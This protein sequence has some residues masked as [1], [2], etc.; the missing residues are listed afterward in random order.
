M[1][2]NEF[3]TKTSKRLGLA[4]VDS[5]AALLP[6]SIRSLEKHFKFQYTYVAIELTEIFSEALRSEEQTLDL[7]II[8][9]ILKEKLP[10]NSHTYGNI[11]KLELLTVND[12]KIDEAEKLTL[13]TAWKYV[14]VGNNKIQVNF[15]IDDITK[16]KIRMS[17][18]TDTAR[19]A[20]NETDHILFTKYPKIIVNRLLYD[21]Y[22]QERKEDL[23][24]FYLNE[25]RRL[26]LDYKPENSQLIFVKNI[27]LRNRSNTTYIKPDEQLQKYLT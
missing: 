6:F 13:N 25:L 14:Y 24:R 22:I 27:G 2:Q 11:N 15:T 12:T 1:K 23:S 26:S 3:L 9:R 21:Y 18:L 8:L 7:N 17:I 19:L 10:E 20:E 5:L 16:I 4:S